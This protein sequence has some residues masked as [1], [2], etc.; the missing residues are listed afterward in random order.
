MFYEDVGLLQKLGNLIVGVG[1]V[2]M[3]LLVMGIPYVKLYKGMY[4]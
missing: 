2:C 3:K 1:K 4:I